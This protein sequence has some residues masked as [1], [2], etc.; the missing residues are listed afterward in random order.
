ML[1][2]SF[3]PQLSE[4]TQKEEHQITLYLIASNHLLARLPLSQSLHFKDLPSIPKI[5]LI[6]F[7]L[8]HVIS[9]RKGLTDLPQPSLSPN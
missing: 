3:Q 6:S 9:H 7:S 2:F 4:C 5:L 1:S 8:I